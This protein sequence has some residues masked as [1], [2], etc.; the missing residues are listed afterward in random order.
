[1]KLVL[2]GPPGSGKGTQARVLANKFGIVHISTGELFRDNVEQQTEVGKLVDGI[3]K[4]GKLVPDEVTIKMISHRIDMDDCK[5]G[6]ILDGFPRNVAQAE[7]LQN[8]LDEKNI[9]LDSII[10]MDC[11]DNLL[12][13]R[14][15]GRFTCSECGEGYHDEFKKPAEENVC[16]NCGAVDKFERR[17]DDNAESVRTRL[18]V[19][20]EQTAPIIPFY[21]ALN[22]LKVVDAVGSM[23][24]VTQR[25][26][27]VLSGNSSSCGCSCG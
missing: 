25:M 27:A 4:S 24:E 19:Y 6:F 2:L 13:K 9:K 21:E 10:Q 15:S 7:A 5:I 8:M 3:I 1:M 16:D 12:V 26:E 11:D 20:N 22:V 17:N 23:D 18:N 14:I